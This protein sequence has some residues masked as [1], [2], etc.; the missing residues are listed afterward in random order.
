MCSRRRALSCFG[1]GRCRHS[2]I[3]WIGATVFLFVVRKGHAGPPCTKAMREAFRG[4]PFERGRWPVN[5]FFNVSKL[6]EGRRMNMTL[7]FSPSE[8]VFA[9][10]N[11]DIADPCHVLFI[12]L[13]GQKIFHLA[14]PLKWD[15]IGRSGR[16][17]RRIVYRRSTTWFPLTLDSHF[18][19]PIPTHFKVDKYGPRARY[20]SSDYWII[21]KKR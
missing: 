6:A 4:S 5:Y 8:Q 16:R 12:D 3:I 21:S 20:S 18:S 13:P 11:W 10:R 14:R 1:H 2:T 7:W 17:K 9:A 15:V 19:Q